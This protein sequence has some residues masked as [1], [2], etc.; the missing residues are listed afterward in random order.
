[1]GSKRSEKG[2][3]RGGSELGARQPRA[4][5]RRKGGASRRSSGAP[6]QRARERVPT[7]SIGLGNLNQKG[8]G[9][10]Q[11][12]LGLGDFRVRATP[13]RRDGRVQFQR[14]STL[15]GLR[16]VQSS[17]AAP[18]RSSVRASWPRP[19]TKSRLTSCSTPRRAFRALT[20]SSGQ[21]CQLLPRDGT[22]RWQ[23]IRAQIPTSTSTISISKSGSTC[24]NT[25]DAERARI[26]ISIPD[27][28][29]GAIAAQLAEHVGALAHVGGV[30]SSVVV[31]FAY[32]LVRVRVWD[33]VFDK[34]DGSRKQASP[35]P[36][37]I[38]SHS[39]SSIERLLRGGAV[40]L[41][42]SFGP[43]VPP[44][45]TP[46]IRVTGPI[47]SSYSPNKPIPHNQAPFRT[48]GYP[49]APA[50]LSLLLSCSHLVF[51]REQHREP[52]MPRPLPWCVP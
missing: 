28:R 27:G 35:R 38:A 1:M 5:V 8:H 37:L 3:T 23:S 44:D 19:R 25:L 20:R 6:P 39:K 26:L 49:C 24:A 22:V 41:E 29:I 43:K 48:L 34:G 47:K 16:A 15:C 11:K 7:A 9:G 14:V 21:R 33:R 36:S 42:A 4:V 51:Y 13:F 40:W 45:N 2:V 17:N 46:G 12:D 32:F 52:H 10:P 50:C 30:K 31:A 18:H